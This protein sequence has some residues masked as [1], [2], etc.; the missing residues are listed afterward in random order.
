[1]EDYSEHAVPANS[2]AARIESV[3]LIQSNAIAGIVGLPDFDSYLYSQELPVPNSSFHHDLYFM[4]SCISKKHFCPGGMA[5]AEWTRSV[6]AVRVTP[7]VDYSTPGINATRGVAYCPPNADLP[8]LLAQS[9][10]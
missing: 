6:R 5:P 7:V 2:G 3:C 9:V 10:S 4:H 1:M 8:F